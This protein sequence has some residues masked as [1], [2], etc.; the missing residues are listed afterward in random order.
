ML[1]N[2]TGTLG[3]VINYATVYITG[4]LFVTLLGIVFGLLLLCLLF[5]I[6]MEF[7]A[8]LVLPLLLGVGAYVSEFTAIV[9]VFLIYMGILIGKNF[10]FK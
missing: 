8:V 9:G 4:S 6:P 3:V 2:T 5:R 7:T 10:F 1:L